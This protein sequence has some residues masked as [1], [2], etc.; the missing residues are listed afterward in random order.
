[1]QAWL[2]GQQRL[3]DVLHLLARWPTKARICG[4]EGTNS[5]A[6]C[7]VQAERVSEEHQGQILDVTLQLLDHLHAW[8][9]AWQAPAKQ[10]PGAGLAALDQGPAPCAHAVLMLLGRLTRRHSIALKVGAPVPH[11]QRCPV[12]WRTL[13][14]ERSAGV[15]APRGTPGPAT[16]HSNQMGALLHACLT[17]TARAGPAPARPACWR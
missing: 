16:I 11:S 7:S 1:M 8:G 9:A 3:C 13:H 12:V 4:G 6:L 14:A 17:S 2:Q 10:Q 5:V 15:H